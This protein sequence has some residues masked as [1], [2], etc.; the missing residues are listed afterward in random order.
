MVDNNKNKEAKTPTVVV[1][2]KSN[3]LPYGTPVLQKHGSVS[4]LTQGG[5]EVLAIDSTSDRRNSI[6]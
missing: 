5:S 4:S 2:T 1:V 6:G 3:K